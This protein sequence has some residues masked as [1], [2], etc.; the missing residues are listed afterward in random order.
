MAGKEKLEDTRPRPLSP[1]Q[2]ELAQDQTPTP[3]QRREGLKPDE[4]DANNDK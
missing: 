3:E 4:L 2:K 1:A